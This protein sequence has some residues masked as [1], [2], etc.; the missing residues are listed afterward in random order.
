MTFTNVLLVC[1]AGIT[2]CAVL[3]FVVETLVA[4]CLH[5]QDR[6]DAVIV[7]AQPKLVE[8]APRELPVDRAA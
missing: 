1:I 2:V 5:E 7:P 6:S 3:V 8:R 4:F